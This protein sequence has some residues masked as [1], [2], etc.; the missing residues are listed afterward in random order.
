MSSMNSSDNNP[1]C[2]PVPEDLVKWLENLHPEITT[3][4]GADLRDLDY[5]SGQ[6][7]VVSY[8]RLQLNKQR[9]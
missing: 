7:N 9:S 5:Q 2:P 1:A 3:S 6:R 8:L 4:M